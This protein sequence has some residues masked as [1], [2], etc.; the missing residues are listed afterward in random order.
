MERDGG[1][2]RLILPSRS[3][4]D[5]HSV[6]DINT[7]TAVIECPNQILSDVVEDFNDDN[8]EENSVDS[9][10]EDPETRNISSVAMRVRGRVDS[11]GAL[12]WSKCR[13]KGGRKLRPTQGLLPK[14]RILP[15]GRAVLEA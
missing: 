13:G 5:D 8:M 10:G 11:D 3:T 12:E 6:M 1:T 7:N 15:R 4:T 14:D 2:G 9:D